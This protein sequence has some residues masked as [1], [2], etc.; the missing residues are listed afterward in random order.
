M[1]KETPSVLYNQDYLFEKSVFQSVK[2]L[3][4]GKDN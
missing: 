2:C 4:T 1:E 3:N